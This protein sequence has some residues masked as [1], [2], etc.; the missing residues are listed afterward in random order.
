MAWY[1][2]RGVNHDTAEVYHGVSIAPRRRIDGSHCVGGTVA[3]AHWDCFNHDI[4]W[5][6][7]SVGLI[8][9]LGHFERGGYDGSEDGQR[10]E[11]G[12]RL[13]GSASS[14]A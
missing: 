8:R 2:Y 11:E 4:R 12:R 5:R 7:V 1:V 6:K 3:L 14:A 10:I 9:F 13:E